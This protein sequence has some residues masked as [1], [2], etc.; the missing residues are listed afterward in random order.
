[1]ITTTETTSMVGIVV[2]PL[3]S[4]SS[5]SS[6][7]SFGEPTDIDGK[8]YN[9][10]TAIC[11]VVSDGE[12]YFQEWVDYHLLAMKFEN[13]YVYDNS[14]KFELQRWYNNT[15]DHPIYDR[16]VMHHQPG[17]GYLKKEDE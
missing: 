11:L 5:S 16:V 9:F 14:D 13:I 4:S 1:M 2:H 7:V 15:R 6:S 3:T 17:P 10:T 8:R 12:Q